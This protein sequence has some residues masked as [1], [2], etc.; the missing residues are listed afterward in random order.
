M[1]RL[2]KRLDAEGITYAVINGMAVTAHGHPRLTLDV[3]VLVVCLDKAIPPSGPGF[4]FC[5]P[6]ASQVD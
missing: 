3:D 4:A 1:R 2:A 5:D 6:T